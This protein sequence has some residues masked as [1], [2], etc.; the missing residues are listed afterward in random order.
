MPRKPKFA[1]EFFGNLLKNTSAST[2]TGGINQQSTNNVSRSINSIASPNM[3]R[4]SMPIESL[5]AEAAEASDQVPANMS[6]SIPLKHINKNRPKRANVKRPTI[7][8][9]AQSSLELDM[10][11]QQD[12][13][14]IVMGN[15]VVNIDELQ[16]QEHIQENAKKISLPTTP[17]VNLVS[18]NA[19][20]L[21]TPISTGSHQ[22][23]SVSNTVEQPKIR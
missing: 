21:T 11:A 14:N 15:E 10:T 16:D 12:Y 17:S 8:N 1:K 4:K 23:K 5:A 9:S 7:K 20:I 3:G 6:E 18:S 13:D 22:I 2:A 19:P